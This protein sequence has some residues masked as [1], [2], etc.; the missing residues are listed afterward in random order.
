MTAP[1]FETAGR[2]LIAGLSSRFGPQTREQIPTLWRRFGPAYFG[3]T[4][5][6]VGKIC[7]GVC[8]NMDGKGSLDYLAGVE[9]SAFDGLPPELTKLTLNPGPY[10]VFPH[11]DHISMIGQTWM[12]IYEGWLPTSGQQLATAPAFE[13]YDEEFDPTIAVGHVEIWVPLRSS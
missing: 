5:G 2:I 12:E 6:Q 1:R 8:W 7:Y 3:R 10:A 13:R 11:E 9:V 4:P